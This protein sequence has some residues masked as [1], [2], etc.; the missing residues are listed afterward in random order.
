MNPMQ[1][2]PTVCPYCGKPL[3]LVIVIDGEDI[4]V[5]AFC[6]GVEKPQSKEE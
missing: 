4:E 1:K 3:K 2:S 6:T 5:R